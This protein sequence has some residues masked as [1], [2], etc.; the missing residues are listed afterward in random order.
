LRLGYG[1]AAPSAN[2]GD[3]DD[4]MSAN[5]F[6]GEAQDRFQQSEFRVANCELGGVHA[7]GNAACTSRQIIS[8]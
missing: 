2:A 3:L 7:D 1:L 4:V 5:R 6:Q 8:D